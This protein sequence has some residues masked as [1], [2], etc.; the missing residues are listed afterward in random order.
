MPN[1]CKIYCM[2]ISTVFAF[3]CISSVGNSPRQRWGRVTPL[4][5]CRD[6]IVTQYPALG[7]TVRH[8]DH[9]DPRRTVLTLATPLPAIPACSK[10]SYSALWSSMPSDIMHKLSRCLHSCC[11]G[12]HIAHM[13]RF[14]GCVCEIITFSLCVPGWR[15]H[16]DSLLEYCLSTPLLWTD[17]H[18]Q[19][20][21]GHLAHK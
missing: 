21:G 14:R 19:F 18:C 3:R 6:I 15:R 9:Q 5:L 4:N 2:I 16:V 13:M 10:S 12:V 7:R 1:S 17:S 11:S 8:L 20:V